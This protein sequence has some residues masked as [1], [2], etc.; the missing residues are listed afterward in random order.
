MAKHKTNVAGTSR[1][2]M[3]S[4]L[5]IGKLAVS[6]QGKLSILRPFSNNCSIFRVP[7]RLRE[8]NEKAYTPQVISIGPLHHGK[9]G[10]KKMEEHKRLY[11]REFLELSEVNVKDFIAAIA[12][13]EDKLRNCYA[14]TFDNLSQEEFVEMVLLDCSFLIMFL[15]KRSFRGLRSPN[16]DRIFNKPWMNEDIIRFDLCLLENQL[17]FFIV[18]DLFKRSKIQD[19][20]EEYSMIEVTRDLLSCEWGSWAPKSS[21]LKEI[22]LSKGKHFVDFLRICQKPGEHM[23]PKKLETP[24]APSVAELHR[25][26]IK[27]KLGSSK[28]LLDIKFDENEGTLEIP[29]LQIGKRTEILF[30]NLQAF[31][32][33]NCGRKKYVRDYIAMLSFLVTSSKDVEILVKYEILRNS[34][35]DNDAVSIL[36]RNLSKENVIN[37]NHFYFSGVVE[38]LNKYYGKRGHNWEAFLEQNSSRNPWTIISVVAAAVLVILTIIQ[39][40]LDHSSSFIMI[41]QLFCLALSLKFYNMVTRA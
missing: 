1:D 25:A 5:D 27:F 3:D 15:L 29:Q 28:N 38:D 22:N 2:Q 17:P 31:E 40:L 33:C 18:E 10:L 41:T 13:K 32:L 23:Q 8:L 34:L 9:Q 14:E 20:H 4:S 39:T 21:I 6:V 35:D 16:T 7:K 12:E 37:A 36:F 26:G 19:R 30:R 24:T 11:L